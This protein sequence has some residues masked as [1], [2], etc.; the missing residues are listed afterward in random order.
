MGTEVAAFYKKQG[1]S[2]YDALM[3]IFKEYGYFLEGLRSLTLKGKDGA[4][5]IQKTLA[6]FREDPLKAIGNLK[7]TAAEDYLASIMTNS[8]GTSNPIQLPKSNVLKYYLEDGTWI[9]LRP[10]GTEPKV[11]FY[12]SVNSGSL[13]ESKEKLARIEQQFMDI[14]NEKISS[15]SK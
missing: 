9:C 6:S 5:L 4:E 10:S 11:K 8:D 14:V 13:Q 15:L 3:A 12:F 7:I 1:M 2:L